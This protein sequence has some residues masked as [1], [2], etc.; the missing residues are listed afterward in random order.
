MGNSIVHHGDTEAHSTCWAILRSTEERGQE[1]KNK[2][3]LLNS[4]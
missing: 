2:T 3:E 1:M 4:R